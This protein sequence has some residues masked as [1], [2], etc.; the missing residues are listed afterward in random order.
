MLISDRRS[1]GEVVV[2]LQLQLKIA[3][4]YTPSIA[5]RT[6][7]NGTFLDCIFF[8][9]IILAATALTHQ[10]ACEHTQISLRSGFDITS[11]AQRHE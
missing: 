2:E 3:N 4:Y 11:G 8:L 10:F 9:L 7:V 1:Q 6:L 5:L